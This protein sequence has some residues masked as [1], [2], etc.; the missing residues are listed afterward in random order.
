M[1]SLFE[2]GRLE[3]PLHLVRLMA[4]KVALEFSLVIDQANPLLLDEDDK[5]EDLCDWKVFDSHG[6][7]PII[8]NISEVTEKNDELDKNKDKEKDTK[9]VEDEKKKVKKAKRVLEPY[10]PDEVIDLR[11]YRVSDDDES[12]SS[13]SKSECSLEPYDLSDDESDLHRDKLP[14]QL[15]DC[16][17]NLRKGDDPDLVSPLNQQKLW[18]FLCLI[19]INY[20]NACSHME[21][22]QL[23]ANCFVGLEHDNR[24]K[25]LLK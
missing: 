15:R 6:P 10:D 3:S 2:T 5:V 9:C 22:Y 19:V 25:K 23:Y 4:K 12:L 16:A 17:A 24:W 14:M 13:D 1:F 20:R 21:A 18:G 11:T 8:T 7:S